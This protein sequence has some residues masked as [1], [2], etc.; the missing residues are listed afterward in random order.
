MSAWCKKELG[1]ITP[2]NITSLEKALSVPNVE[3][4]PVVYRMWQNA[5]I[6]NQFFLIENRQ[7]IG[8]DVNLYDAG[9]LIYHVDD[10][11]NGNQNENHYMVD[12]EQADGNRNLN[13]GQN[14]GDAGDPFPGSS[15]NRRF[16]WNTNPNSKDYVLNNTF[17]SVRKIEN[18]GNAMIA[19]FDVSS[20]PFLFTEKETIIFEQAFGEPLIVKLVTISNYGFDDLII[21]D[22]TSQVGPFTLLTQPA[23]PLAANESITLKFGL[24]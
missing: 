7:K 8:F 10:N 24:V 22:I 16:D 6:T 13:N 15:N 18:N 4:N 2:V 17:V 12:L 23:Y 9:F 3:E 5:A 19:N 21:N 11:L 1:W 20:G 14:R